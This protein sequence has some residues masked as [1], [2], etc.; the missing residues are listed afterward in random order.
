MYWDHQDFEGRREAGTGAI[1]DAVRMGL[2]M[3][4]KQTVGPP[5]IVMREQKIAK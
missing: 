4:L 2:A 5:N 1:V 3:H